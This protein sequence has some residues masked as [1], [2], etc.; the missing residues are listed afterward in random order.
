MSESE[1]KYGIQKQFREAL[2]AL[3]VSPE[4]QVEFTGPCDVPVEIIEDYL[5][6]CGSYKNYFKDE[7]SNQIVEE[8][9]DLGYWVD[10]MPDTVFRDTNIESMQQP[11]WEPLRAKAKE[12]LLKLNWPIEPP[13]P[14]VNEG[15]GVYRRK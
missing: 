13:P 12:L 1:I 5:L 8:I 14:F 3:A 11:E 7:L 10:K 2:Q 4:L 9:T 15:D 6:W